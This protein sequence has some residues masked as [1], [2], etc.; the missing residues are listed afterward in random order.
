MA[1]SS[2]NGKHN[3]HVMPCTTFLVSSYDQAIDVAC[4]D[5]TIKTG[6]LHKTHRHFALTDHPVVGDPRYGRGNKNTTGM[7]LT[8]VVLDFHCP[9]FYREMDFQI[10]HSL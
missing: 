10:N 1:P 7:K 2:L 8:A 5:V 4:V 6:R 3:Q 9:I